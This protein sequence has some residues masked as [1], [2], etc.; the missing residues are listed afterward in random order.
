V[1]HEN[2]RRFHLDTMLRK[3]KST[4]RKFD[5][6]S[7]GKNTGLLHHGRET[8]IFVLISKTIL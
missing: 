2:S 3:G 7:S 8:L 4:E 6:Q 5:E 1:S